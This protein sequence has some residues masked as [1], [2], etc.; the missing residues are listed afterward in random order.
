MSN[1]KVKIIN[2]S[3]NELPAY[4]TLSSAGMDVRASLKEPVE[5]N[6]CNAY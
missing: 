5:I 2:S 6:R 3:N 1:I 4:E